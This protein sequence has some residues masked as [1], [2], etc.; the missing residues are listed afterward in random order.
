MCYNL[1]NKIAIVTG[2]ARGIGR[3][4]VD[5]LIA[6]GAT[7]IIFDKFFPEDFENYLKSANADRQAV[8]PKEIDITNSSRVEKLVE[9]IVTQYGKVDILIN[10]AGITRDR[11]L[12][13]MTDEDWDAVLAVNL[14]GAFITTKAV[15]RFMARQRAGKII[16]ISSVVGIMGNAGQV[17]YA[18]SKAGLIGFS[19]SVAKELATR[20][21]TVNCVAPGYVETEM[22]AA[23]TEEQKNAFLNII[24]LKR[25]CKPSEIAGVVAFLA[26]EKADYITG[27]VIV[28]DG[29]MVM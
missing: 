29:G 4:I 3:A 21:V 23:L 8:V 6:N 24:P 7:A 12:I 16:N 15:S 9:E 14:K 20:N 2:G 26:S 13:R 17:N 19:K 22:T 28:V 11:L 10:N 27:Q 1:T 5:E 25:P 18:A